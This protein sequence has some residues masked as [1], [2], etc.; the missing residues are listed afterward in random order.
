MHFELATTY[1]TILIKTL[2]FASIEGTS[3]THKR[4]SSKNKT[5]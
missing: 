2:K 3:G 4:P 1:S 5:S